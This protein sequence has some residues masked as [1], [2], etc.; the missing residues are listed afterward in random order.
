MGDINSLTEEEPDSTPLSSLDLLNRFCLKVKEEALISS[1]AVQRIRGLAISLLRATHLQSKNQ[2]YKILQA[3]GINPNTMPQLEDV[4]APSL[5]EH[6]DTGLTNCSNFDGYFPNI[7]PR[8][9]KLGTRYELKQKKNGKRRIVECPERFYYVSLLASLELMLSNQKILDMVANPKKEDL[10]SSLLCDFTDGSII[11]T[12]G[13][14]SIEPQSLKIILYYD[15]LEITNEQ[16]KRKHKLAMFY[17]QLGNLYFEYRSKLKS[18]NLLAITEQ[19]LLKKYGMDEILKP[20]VEE[21]KVLGDDMGHDFQ[22]QNGIVRLRGALLA[23]IA[24]TPASQLLGGFKESVGG[25][26]R[27]CRHCM[28]NFEDMQSKFREEEY[29]LRNQAMH[30]YHLNQ[31]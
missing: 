19:R 22:L 28:A 6:G 21:L 14:F 13:I 10:D 30:D 3:N 2:V 17:F 1:N 24:D 16:T 29:E 31:L 9:I 26:K 25:A 15:D 5:W 12:H 7:S 11:Q 27:K 23:V 8:E 4:F 18:I 20:F